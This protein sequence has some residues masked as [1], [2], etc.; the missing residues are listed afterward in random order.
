MYMY[1]Q[2][3]TKTIHLMTLLCYTIFTIAVIVGAVILGWGETSAILLLVVGMIVSWTVHISERLSE[4][5]RLWLYTVLSM[6]TFF[7]YGIHDT[8]I[9]ALAPAM[10][11]YIL[12]Y[13][14][15]EK[16]SYIRLCAITYYVTMCYDFIYVY[17]GSLDTSSYAATMIRIVF[18]LVVV[19]LAERLSEMI[20]RM[21]KKNRKRTEAKVKELEEFNQRTEDFM[22]NASHELRT[23]INAV[24]GITAVMLKYEDDPKKKEDLLSIQMAGNRLFNQIEDIL[25]YTEVGAGSIIISEENYMITSIIND[26]ITEVRMIKREKPIDLVF[27][28]DYKIPAVLFGDGR[29]IKKIIKHLLDNAVKFTKKG[30]VYVRVSALH[31]SYGINL[32]IEIRD[33]GVGIT[34]EDLGKIKDKFFQAN[35]GRNRTYGGLGLGIP[36]VHGMVIAMGGFMQI[37]STEQVGTIVSASIPQKVIDPA[38]CME[39]S[40]PDDLCVAVYIRPEKFENPDVR[41]YYSTMISHI[42]YGLG[43]TV[44]RVFTMD[45]LKRLVAIYRLTHLFVGIEEYNEDPVFIDGIEKSVKIMV[46]TYDDVKSHDNSR[47]TYIRRPYYGLSIINVL[48]SQEQQE[49]DASGERNFI[50]PGVKVL[51][52]D[53]EPM[54]LMVAEGI[55]MAYQMDVKT[56]GSG[57]EAIDICKQDEFD[58]I[59]LDHMM[60]GMDGIETLNRLRKSMLDTGKSHVMIAFTANVVSG[61]REMFL[62]EGFNE[63]ISKP[64]EELELK[65]LLKKVLPNSSIIYVDEK[66]TQP[67]PAKKKEVKV[68]TAVHTDTHGAAADND[69]NNDV[70]ARLED[71]GINTSNGLQYCRGDAAFYEE[72]LAQFVKSAERKVTDIESSFKNEDIKNYQI[73]VHALKSS[74]KMIGADEL[75]EMAKALE[76]AAKEQNTGY[77]K[78]NHRE[79]MEKYHEMV[80]FIS[81]ALDLGSEEAD[82]SDDDPV[83]GEE[84]SGDDLIACLS[85]LKDS[86]DTFESDKAESLLADISTFLY[87]GKPAGKL[88]HD[89]AGDIEDFELGAAAEKVEKIINGI[90][91]GEI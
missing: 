36:I 33:T 7:Y 76:D 42:V 35:G 82:A 31:K 79:L 44:H 49:Y 56:A 27:D 23:P 10:V 65:R 12:L 37:E 6:L 3:N 66:D 67:V 46:T 88:L 16:Y 89:V 53:D 74:S 17:D 29:K 84:V 75:S 8:S 39:L 20:I 77:I 5:A 14:V 72:L 25:D 87:K 43:M 85:E 2:E 21:R 91:G 24:T 45:E 9:Y 38:P 26:I 64:I 90:K 71:K 61:A 1:E 4:S 78:D 47:L 52:V 62:Q 57:P 30:G 69:Q 50:C 60:P 28:I 80:Q 51:V 48:N 58:L 41:D 18:N 19:F 55:F 86:L 54:N 32:C 81:D 73:M 70:L 63:F 11:M 22:A 40:N 13:T 83:S 59:F 15:M 68:E 34:E